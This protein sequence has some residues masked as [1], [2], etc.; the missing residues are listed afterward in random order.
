MEIELNLANKKGFEWKTLTNDGQKFFY[1]SIANYT[2]TELENET[3]EAFVVIKVTPN[4]VCIK[5]DVFRTIPI[6]YKIDNN[7]VIIS[8][9]IDNLLE[10]GESEIDSNMRNIYINAG[11]SPRYSTLF[12]NVFQTR[13]SE[14]VTFDIR[15]A[16]VSH[17]ADNIN[18]NVDIRAND[19]DFLLFKNISQSI[20]DKMYRDLNDY[21]IYLPL[22]DGYDSLFIACLLKM[23]SFENVKCF[24]YGK[25]SSEVAK[26][27]KNIADKL[28]FEWEFYNYEREDW[29]K[30]RNSDIFSDYL[31][32]A[33]Q[34][35]N[36]VHFQDFL[37]VMK[38]SE[39]LSFEERMN[40]IFL[41]GHTGTIGGGNLDSK[42][43]ENITTSNELIDFII[44]KDFNLQNN[45]ICK[46][47]V[48]DIVKDEFK[49]KTISLDNITDFLQ[50]WDIK[51][52]QSKV[53]INSLRIYEFF[54]MKWYLPLQDKFLVRSLYNL[55]TSE[56]LNKKRYK[57]LISQL[58]NE[59]EIFISTKESKKSKFKSLFKK[60]LLRPYQYVYFK[61]EIINHQFEWFGLFKSREILYY[62]FKNGRGFPAIISKVY[63]DFLESKYEKNKK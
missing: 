25:S 8:D 52:R 38:I 46:E 32:Y 51:E 23:N 12:E 31:N 37:A 60:K 27:S 42:K 14:T 9:V 16:T 2:W 43:I 19:L 45:E 1:K 63:V 20:S 54:E 53:I 21:T 18:Y 56:K 30:L 11:F 40:S 49:D 61:L 22:S 47:Y 6:F 26:K 13:A 36:F 17:L 33:G 41:P 57:E 28:G 35:T 5:S 44:K 24:S 7:K 4:K 50:I 15:N 62:L 10:K 58:A 55:E 59:F 34:G 29:K 3:S 39:K 48:R